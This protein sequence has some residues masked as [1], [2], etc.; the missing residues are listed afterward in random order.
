MSEKGLS[1]YDVQLVNRDNVE[2][3]GPLFERNIE[4]LA[5]GNRIEQRDKCKQSRT[6]S[7]AHLIKQINAV[8]NLMSNYSNE[9]QIRHLL[10]K[11]EDSLEEIYKSNQE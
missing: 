2:C 7:I 3:G 1:E 4:S 6:A 11:F 10:S 8:S 5:E 9:F